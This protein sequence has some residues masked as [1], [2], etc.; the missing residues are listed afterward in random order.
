MVSCSPSPNATHSASGS[1]VRMSSGRSVNVRSSPG[2]LMSMSRS[3]MLRV[4]GSLL[5]SMS[6]DPS[7]EWLARNERASVS[8]EP[9]S[10]G[11]LGSSQRTP[12]AVGESARR[13]EHRPILSR[14][15]AGLVSRRSRYKGV[16]PIPHAD[17]QSGGC[18]ARPTGSMNCWGIWL[19]GRATYDT[20]S[21]GAPRP[22]GRSERTRNDLLNGLI[23]RDVTVPFIC[24]AIDELQRSAGTG[25]HKRQ[26]SGHRREM[27][28]N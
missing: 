21:C 23:R 24:R 3:S 6:L 27:Q 13:G 25:L 8:R 19:R 7:C 1:S 26:H 17:C 4:A 10:S 22:D 11:E 18:G 15:S 2:N 20:C 28:S 16:S 5:I 14:W 12:Q 9:V